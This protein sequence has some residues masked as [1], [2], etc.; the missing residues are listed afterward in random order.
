LFH[1]QGAGDRGKTIL[2]HYPRRLSLRPHSTAGDAKDALQ[3]CHR[4]RL[5][6]KHE[7]PSHS[8]SSRRYDDL[9]SRSH[10]DRAMS[11][12]IAVQ[13]RHL[14]VGQ[15]VA[16]FRMPRPFSQGSG[17]HIACRRHH[18]LD[19]K[20]LQ[21]GPVN[22]REDLHRRLRCAGRPVER[23]WKA[24]GPGA[25]LNDATVQAVRPLRPD[26]RTPRGVPRTGSAGRV[27]AHGLPRHRTE[28]IS[29]Q[30]RRSQV[31]DSVGAPGKIR[32]SDPQ[33]RSL[34]PCIDSTWK[35]CKPGSK[36]PTVDQWLI[37]QFA[38]HP[39]HGAC[40]S[41]CRGTRGSPAQ[42]RAAIERPDENTEIGDIVFGRR[43]VAA[44]APSSPAPLITNPDR[45]RLRRLDRNAIHSYGSMAATEPS[46]LRGSGSPP[47]T[48]FRF[49]VDPRCRSRL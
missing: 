32:T 18:D 30:S 6:E 21:L 33:I 20:T 13:P 14:N 12:F 37:C 9:Q 19:S 7:V 45:P 24:R 4:N 36:W 27:S 28:I 25:D 11:E 17:S 16:D 31:I 35:F 34:Q 15:K 5:W 46:P 10:R 26:E 49:G 38:N 40:L 2:S 3:L 1:N 8:L 23:Q 22:G 47:L 42:V 39:I 43:G 29:G 48:N 41:P 44:W